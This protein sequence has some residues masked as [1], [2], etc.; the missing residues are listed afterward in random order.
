M[1]VIRDLPTP[2]CLSVVVECGED[3]TSA[4]VVQE[5]DVCQTVSQS[6]YNLGKELI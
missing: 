3:V 4:A 5:Y 2:S 6:Q 1:Q